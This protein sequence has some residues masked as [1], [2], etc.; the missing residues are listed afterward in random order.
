M[1]SISKIN[2]YSVYAV[3]LIPL[4]LL[5][6]PFLPDLI[7]S[8]LSLTFIYILTITRDTKYIYNYFS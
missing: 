7:V 4:A 6:G 1:Q 2:Q 5:T 8:L 3:C